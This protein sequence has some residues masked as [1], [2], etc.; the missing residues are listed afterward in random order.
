MKVKLDKEKVYTQVLNK[1]CEIASQGLRVEKEKTFADKLFL[2]TERNIEECF[3]RDKLE[4][5][6]LFRDMLFSS[7]QE[8][9]ELSEEEYVLIYGVSL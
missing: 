7:D 3:L 8:F 5:L 9:I 6:A 2:F 1:Y 4:K